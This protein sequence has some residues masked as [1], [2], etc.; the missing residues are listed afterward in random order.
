[1]IPTAL[2]D[3]HHEYRHVFD[4]YVPI[5]IGVFALFA[6]LIVFF[7]VRGRFRPPSRARWWH[8]NK[9]VESAYAVVLV[10]VA[11]FLL[12]VTFSA[13][14]RIDSVSLTEHPRLTVDVTGSQ[15]EWTFHYPAYGITGRSGAVG[16]SAF[17]VPAGEPVRLNIY[18]TDV[19]HSLWFPE[20]GFK[21]DAFPGTRNVV[22]L[23]FAQ[24]GHY[25]GHCAE[26][27]GVRHSDMVFPIHV[28]APARFLAWARSGGRTAT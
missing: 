23:E 14:H 4:I 1:M 10:C 25:V 12:Y 5:G 9:P 7:A 27:C 15:W 19:I 24:R 3:N 13:E 6:G 11:A 16:R 2:V 18:S 26:Y 21:R 22:V 8:D 17:V 28:V 20:I